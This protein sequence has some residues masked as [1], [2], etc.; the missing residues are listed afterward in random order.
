M[1]NKKEPEIKKKPFATTP[2]SELKGVKVAA[3]TPPILKERSKHTKKPKT[4]D[5]GVTLFLEAMADVKRLNHEKKDVKTKTNLPQK[6]TIREIDE[7]EQ[8]FFLDA[9]KALKLDTIFSND[10]KPE[11][12]IPAKKAN[13]LR[14][15]RRGS[16]TI[17][18]ELDIHGL[19]EDEAIDA[20]SNFISGAF[21][22]DQKA[23][24]VITGDENCPNN[25]PKSKKMVIEWL[26]TTGNLFIDEFFNAPASICGYGALVIILKSDKKGMS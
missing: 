9:L 7:K 10:L 22:R 14:Q 12:N 11:R 26:E 13:W 4:E 2:F 8:K 19:H 15:L 21:R 17:N 20:L 1:K 24:L 5:D 3:E 18:Y 6:A 25:G 16:I 23:V